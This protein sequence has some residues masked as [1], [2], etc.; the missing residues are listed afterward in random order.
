[1]IQQNGAETIRASAIVNTLLSLAREEKFHRDHYPLKSL[2]QEILNLIRGQIP[3]DIDI[4]MTISNEIVIFADKQKIQQV[5]INLLKNSADAMAGKGTICINASQDLSGL[6]ITVSDDGP[7]IPEQIQGKIFDP[8]FS[9]KDTGEG[10]G[11]GLFI[12]HDIIVQHGG[13]IT[14][15]SNNGEGTIFTIIMPV[16]EIS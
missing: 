7:G 1:M 5:F 3:S 11:L 6:T 8:F 14:V 12:V 2:C 4:E 10:S 9:T 15:G 13:T 16:R